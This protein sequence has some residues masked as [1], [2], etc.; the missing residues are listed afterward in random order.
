VR[1]KANK[2]AQIG[3]TLTLRFCVREKGS[4]VLDESGEEPVKV[5]LGLGEF[6]PVLE[7]WL[8]GLPKGERFVFLLEPHQA[9]GSHD[10]ARLR[11]FS[12][13][14]FTEENL[15]VGALVQFETQTGHALPG[16][17]RA[18]VDGEV[19]VDFNHPWA[20]KDVEFEVEILEIKSKRAAPGTQKKTRK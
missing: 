9:F 20:G 13:A 1:G 7:T 14:D 11:K 3:D 8:E 2:T 6:S 4:E 12:S 17:I 15:K 5:R 19:L 16:L 18:I 10:P